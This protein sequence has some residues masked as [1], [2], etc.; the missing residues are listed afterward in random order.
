MAL[1][2]HLSFGME[3][4]RSQRG[5][6]SDV[7][8]V[9]VMMILAYRFQHENSEQPI[10]IQCCLWQSS[11]LQDNLDR[12]SVALLTGASSWPCQKP[13]IFSEIFPGKILEEENPAS[14]EMDILHLSS[15]L[16]HLT[17]IT[18]VVEPHNHIAGIWLA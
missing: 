11:G 8:N 4:K 18:V 5:C 6:K 16:Q 12:S 10:Q 7:K 9:T 2:S 15:H 1:Y 13:D 3:Q 17:A 14:L